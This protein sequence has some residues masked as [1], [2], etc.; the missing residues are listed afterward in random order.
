VSGRSYFGGNEAA[1]GDD[2][3]NDARQKAAAMGA[4][5]IVFIDV[6][7]SGMLNTGN[8]RGRAYRCGP[9]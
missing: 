3:M 7:T 6:D 8:A 2:A 5:D 1:R 9:N 4:T